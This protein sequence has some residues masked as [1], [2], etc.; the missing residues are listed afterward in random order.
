MNDEPT[1]TAQASQTNN[2]QLL[3]PQVVSESAATATVVR[4]NRLKHV[5]D[6]L[7]N[8]DILI[9][10]QL[11]AIYYM[12]C[13]FLRF[14][15]RAVVQFAMLTPKPA[16][17]PEPPNRPFIGAIGGTNFL[18]LVLHLY[19][20]RPSAGEVT[21][22]YL[23]GGLLIDFIGQRGPTS[24]LH[25]ICLD[26]SVF[27]LQVIMLSVFLKRLKLK[28]RLEAGSGET[29]PQRNGNQVGAALTD[30]SSSNRQDVDSEE[31]G[32]LRRSSALSS[33][34]GEGP[35]EFAVRDENADAITADAQMYALDLFSGQAV[36]V[37]VFAF[38]TIREQYSAYQTW[39][40]STDHATRTT[41]VAMDLAGRRL[42]FRLGLGGG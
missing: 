39:D 11:S 25:L 40:P 12:D 1:P 6:L 16:I 2:A 4:A 42:G 17:F 35:D 23:H 19:F 7:R 14:L 26:L 33:V 5:E 32:L 10:A 13:S 3:D 34:A 36:V 20:A 38:D 21:R 8:L 31:R 27:L 15:V 24:K 29:R 37:E 18:C 41:N 30:I 9:Y 22:G 28:E